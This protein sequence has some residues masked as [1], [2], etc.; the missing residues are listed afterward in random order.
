MA[1]AAKNEQINWHFNPPS[2]PHF[3]GLWKAGIKS[4]KTHLSRIIGKHVLSY[5]E[6]YTLLTLVE[7]VLNSRPLMP[8]T[9]DID[10]IQALTPGHFL[11]TEP[12]VS[13]PYP[14]LTDLP[15]SR[16]SRWQLL[17]RLHHDFW[18]RYSQEYLHTLQQ[19][20]K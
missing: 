11:T 5:E 7:S 12:L 4:V 6:F 1:N 14:D 13:I 2:A 16:L 8:I 9:S 18:K 3:G 17:Q 19:R 20:S 10:D 15:L